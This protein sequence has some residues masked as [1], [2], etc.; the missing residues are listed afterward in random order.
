MRTLYDSFAHMQ[1]SLVKYMKELQE[2]TKKKERIESELNIARKIQ[3]GMLP[4]L[5]EEIINGNG[6]SLYAVL[7]PAKEVGGDLYNYYTDNNNLYF[8]IGD[9]SGKG[10]PASLLMAITS[11]LFRMLVPR[12]H[13]PREIVVDLNRMACESNKSDI[14]TTLIVGLLDT[15]TG[16]LT[17]CNAGHNRP[18][19]LESSKDISVIS[20]QQNIPVG[21][22]EDYEYMEETIHINRGTTIFLYTDGV[23]EAENEENQ[24]YGEKRLVEVLE[25]NRN[26]PP[27]DLVNA[28]LSSLAG[29][30]DGSEANDD[31][32]MLVINYKNSIQNGQ[33]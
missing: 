4:V 27:R 2:T 23:T 9:V 20:V 21:I 30:K 6:V 11:S 10:V 5:S 7:H 13:S 12:G 32:T 28:V 15:V 31:L 16:E 26:Q 3:M 14:F 1:V 19:L 8:I 25:K 18:L 33:T 22:F 24:L 29:Y 17:L